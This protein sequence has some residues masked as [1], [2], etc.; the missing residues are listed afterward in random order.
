MHHANGQAERYVRTVLNLICV[1]TRN[2]EVVWSDSIGKI[3][4]VLNITKQKTTQ[5][6]AINL[7]IGTDATTP[8]IHALIRDAAVDIHCYI[9]EHNC[10]ARWELS[11]GN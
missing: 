11:R 6:S 9:A 4:L 3:Q 7:L 5:S 10:H 8:A 1:E 2:N